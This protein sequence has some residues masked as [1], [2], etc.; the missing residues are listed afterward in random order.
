MYRSSLKLLHKGFLDPK[1]LSSPQTSKLSYRVSEVLSD[2]ESRFERAEIPEAKTSARYLLSAVF[3]ETNLDKF[4]ASCS[5]DIDLH[6]T[7]K[8]VCGTNKLIKQ[9]IENN[10]N[11]RNLKNTFLIQ[12]FIFTIN[13]QTTN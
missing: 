4:M 1:R 12:P 3:N 9:I 11:R 8:Q 10:Y 7:E 13:S 2:L 5:P 6:M